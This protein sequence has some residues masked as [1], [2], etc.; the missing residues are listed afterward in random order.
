MDYTESFHNKLRRKAKREKWTQITFQGNT[1]RSQ[2][3]RNGWLISETK[4]G[5]MVI[6]L[7]G[8]VQHTHLT[9]HQAEGVSVY[10]PSRL[11][12]EA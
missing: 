4:R 12:E 8:D 6:H 11:K 9:K 7:V 5:T 10:K 1:M 3:V 2:R